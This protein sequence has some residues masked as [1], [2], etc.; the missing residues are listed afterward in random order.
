MLKSKD[1]TANLSKQSSKRAL[2]MKDLKKLKYEENIE[3]RY[4]LGKV[5]GHG[6]FGTVFSAQQIDT[7]KEVAVKI[8]RKKAIQ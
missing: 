2:H 1:I 7:G 6:A 3:R 5:L 4:K 8:M